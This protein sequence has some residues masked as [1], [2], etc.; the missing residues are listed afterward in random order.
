MINKKRIWLVIAVICFF[1]SSL[2]GQPRGN[3]YQNKREK[4][5]AMKIAFITQRLSLNREEAQ[6]FWPV[7]N[8]Y[9][10]EKGKLRKEK[11]EQYRDYK[12]NFDDL[13]DE[14]ITKFVDSQIIYRQRELDIQKKYHI[15][16][17]G[18][19]PI[20]KVALLYKAEEDFKKHLLK[21]AQSRT[22]H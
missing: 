13:S 1:A 11:R 22:A 5:E 9:D 3:D 8:E 7:Y 20:R 18:V 10:A 21:E 6:K 17:K 19:L 16:L 4:I 14:E 12:T 2:I 15:D